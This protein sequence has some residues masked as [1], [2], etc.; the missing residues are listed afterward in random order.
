MCL[1]YSKLHAQG[2]RIC[3]VGGWI[4]NT[5]YIVYQVLDK[6]HKTFQM[7]APYG[8]QDILRVS[9]TVT[10]NVTVTVTGKC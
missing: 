8:R 7:V 4:F 1:S 3:Q 9:V 5:I 2:T 6:I 10:V